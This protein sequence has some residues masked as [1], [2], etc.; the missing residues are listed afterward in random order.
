M[1]PVLQEWREEILE[2]VQGH[3]ALVIGVFT[4]SGEPLF[5]N[6]GMR[7]L[8]G[9]KALE[10]NVSSFLQAPSFSRLRFSS[11]K[12][13]PSYT[14]LFNFSDL[15]KNYHTVRGLAWAR[16]DQILIL[17][18]H[19]IEMLQQTSQAINEVNSEVLKLQRSL[20][21]EKRV[22]EQTLVELRATQAALIQ[23]EKLNSL[24]QLVAGVAHEINSPIA[25]VSSNLFS[26]KE[27]IR[28]MLSA[29]QSL[30]TLTASQGP[31]VTEKVAALRE[32]ADLDFLEEDVVDLLTGSLDGLSR[33]KA[34]V[35]D[36]RDFSRL[37]Q[38]DQQFFDLNE[39]VE[40]TLSLA[41]PA[42][43]KERVT[44]VKELS[45]LP[46]V[47]GYPA[48]FNQVVLNLIINAIQAMAGEERQQRE[49]TVTTRLDGENVVLEIADTGAGIPKDILDN[50][51]DPF[52]TTKPV[53]QGT[54][55]GLSV[56]YTVVSERHSGVI[57][58]SSEV[59]LGS[60]FTIELPLEAADV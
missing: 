33:V 22:L 10:T 29:Y 49:L 51:F 18:E 32:D 58:V 15:K 53:G 42:L 25:F 57:R 26:L 52:F 13:Q 60:V 20:A 24:G 1:N 37:D 5:L 41:A 59:G 30:E 45:P 3:T 55:L 11:D 38:A 9:G 54:G 27:Q 47:P 48:Q 50:V 56:A 43:R 17:A 28:D 4:P 34:I 39:S 23:S 46:A 16:A 19:D 2:F 12:T 44:V 7:E 6:Q 40:T 36:L 31:Q 8:L 21:Q 14:G 35:D